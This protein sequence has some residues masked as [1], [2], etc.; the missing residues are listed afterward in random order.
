M[1]IA[2]T[3]GVGDGVGDAASDAAT[4]YARFTERKRRVYTVAS[5]A[6]LLVTVISWLAREPGDVM[7]AVLYPVLALVLLLFAV[8]IHR[9]WLS[10]RLLEWLVLGLVGTIILGRLAWHVYLGGPID[11]R[12]LV[13]TGAHYWSVGALIVGGFVLLDRRQGL[14]LG[15]GVLLVSLVLVATGAGPELIGPDGSTQALLYLVRVHAFLVLLLVLASAIATLREQLSRALARS[16]ALE[17]LATT[18]P[19]TGL[20]N[21]RAATE[22]LEHQA[23]AAERYDRPLSVVAID[24]DRF[25][26]INDAH[27]HQAGDEVLRTIADVLRRHA[28][29]A[30][31]VARW[32]GEE[33]LIVAPHTTRADARV[34]AERCRGAIAD[35]RPGGFDIT[36]TFGVAQLHAGEDVDNLLARAD[37]LLYDAKRHGRDQVLSEQ[38]G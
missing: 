34:L 35:A 16:E 19:L 7:L 27:G 17:E 23:L 29:D 37:L 9:D 21:R 28:R 1:E 6:G 33:F 15:I 20:A 5:L 3:R 30:D 18:D 12:L 38:P 24:V 8:A 25:K 10:M 14:R 2:S 32:G 36:A 4:E 26:S 13:L 22:V 11:E 31:L